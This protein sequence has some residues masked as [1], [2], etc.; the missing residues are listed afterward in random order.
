MMRPD[1]IVFD[2]GTIDSHDDLGIN[3]RYDDRLTYHR[4][5]TCAVLNGTGHMAG[6]DGLND[7]TSDPAYA[8]YGPSS[9]NEYT[10]S[11]SNFASLYINDTVKVTIPCQLY[12]VQTYGLIPEAQKPSEG[13]FVPLPE[14]KQDSADLT[15]LFL[16]YTGR[17]VAPIEDPWFSAN[18]LHLVDSQFPLVR[19][20]YSRDSPIS[21]LI[22]TEQH[23]FCTHGG[24]CTPF[25]GFDQVQ[26]VDAFNLALTHHQNATFDR[27]LR[28]VD[29]SSLLQIVRPLSLTS[30]PMLAVNASATQSH[31][32]SL[33]L[34]KN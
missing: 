5:T 31:T 22:C 11:Y 16:S 13:G 6:W 20:Q 17:Y 24:N 14:L 15:L 23:K 25:L 3:A 32:L 21:T 10:Y 18:R 9:G 1:A 19:T 26:H 29:A 2:T 12:A 33:G 7:S 28:A 27:M 30:T 4:I 8:Y 34:P